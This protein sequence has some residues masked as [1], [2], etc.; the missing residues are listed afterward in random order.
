M[1]NAYNK[2]PTPTTTQK[3]AMCV[4][5]VESGE[6]RVRVEGG[7]RRRVRGAVVVEVVGHWVYHMGGQC[8]PE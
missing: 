2:K 1:R 3:K 6:R 8:L 7:K 5:L 4:W